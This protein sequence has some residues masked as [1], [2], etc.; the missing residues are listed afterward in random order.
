[1]LRMRDIPQLILATWSAYLGQWEDMS[2]QE[3]SKQPT[4]DTAEYNAFFP[5]PYSLG[6]FT[7]D[8]SAS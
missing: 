7:R 1:M 5:S 6:E 3:L 2:K 8:L 4:P